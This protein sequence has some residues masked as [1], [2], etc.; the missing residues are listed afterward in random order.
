MEEEGTRIISSLPT[1]CAREMH[2]YNKKKGEKKRERGRGGELGRAPS[3][4]GKTKMK[5]G[6]EMWD[7]LLYL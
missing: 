1:K 5:G 3:R 7:V 2:L 6:G 4:M